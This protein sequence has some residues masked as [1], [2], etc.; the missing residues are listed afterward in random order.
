[1]AYSN[2]V[3]TTLLSSIDKLAKNPEKF[4]VH[5]GKDFTRNRKL[6]FKDFCELP[7]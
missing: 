4:A 2:V 5:P 3:K 6:Y 7:G 1:M